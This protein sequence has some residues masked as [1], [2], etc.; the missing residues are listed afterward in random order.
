MTKTKI[1]VE[2]I[3]A[4]EQSMNKISSDGQ[5]QKEIDAK[6]KMESEERRKQAIEALHLN[7]NLVVFVDQARDTGASSWLNALPIRE[8]QLNL[9][10]EQFSDALALRYNL[11][12]KG[13]PSTCVCGSPFSISHALDCKK[14]GFVAQGHDNLRDL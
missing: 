9:N 4:Q 7:E 1:H 5:S 13:L 14:G 10:K 11:P 12:L 8:Q 3:L 6:V 2:T